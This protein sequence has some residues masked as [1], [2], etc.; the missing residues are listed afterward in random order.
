MSFVDSSQSVLVTGGAGF[1]GSH[2]V[3]RLLQ[4][5]FR[6]TVLDNL[7]TGKKENVNSR[8]IFEQGDIT[9]PEIS[10]VFKK[11][12]PSFV[13]HFAALPRIAYS[14]ENPIETSRVNILGSINV[15]KAAAD[16]G[17]SRLIFISS[18]SVYGNQEEGFLREDMQ[19]RPISP[20][21]LQKLAGEQFAQLFTNLYNLP[22][23]C[24]RYFNVYG[25]RID[26]E[27]EY[28]LVIGKFLAEA[29]KGNSLP[30]FGDG[31]QTRG[32]C[33]IDDVIEGTR[34]TMTC[35]KL[36]GGEIINIGSEQAHSINEVASLIGGKTISLPSRL[37]DVLHTRADLNLA[38]SLLDWEPKVSLQEG[39][40]KTKQW[41]EGAYGK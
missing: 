26:F 41:F 25:P 17:V 28:S 13:F 8:A 4:E 2:M 23:V 37:G 29:A 7:S 9:S 22:V 3:D 19:P 32:F 35:D 38:K 14:V 5:G 31:E 24:I 30:I 15:F 40:A 12:K 6:V 18:S 20:Y 33:Y 16:A 36:Q 11:H 21:A 1:I 27:S 34:K 39:I 10:D